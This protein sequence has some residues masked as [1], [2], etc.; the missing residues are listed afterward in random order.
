MVFIRKTPQYPYIPLLLIQD[1][2]NSQQTIMLALF[3]VLG[4]VLV[5]GLVVVP[6][7][8]EVDAKCEGTK[9][10]GDPCKPKKD[11]T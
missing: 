1:M 7:M 2:E 3:I 9:K 4:A 6:A 8:E 10:N 11:K 5:T